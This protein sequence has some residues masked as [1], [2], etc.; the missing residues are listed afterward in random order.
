MYARRLLFVRG[1]P[2]R[3]GLVAILVA[4]LSLVALALVGFVIAFWPPGP[5]PSAHR[6]VSGETASTNQSFEGGLRVPAKK[7]EPPG[8]TRGI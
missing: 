2:P 5:R 3:S 4:I 6:S 1:P 7:P 8:R